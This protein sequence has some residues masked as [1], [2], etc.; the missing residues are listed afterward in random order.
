MPTS[1]SRWASAFVPA[2]GC[3]SAVPWA[4][5]IVAAAYRAGAPYVQVMW[6]D[7][8]VAKSRYLLAPDGSFGEVPYGQ[9]EAMEGMAERGD[10]VVSISASDPE[11]FAAGS[12]RS[13]E[14]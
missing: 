10:A 8:E 4:R 7:E 5:R 9:A 14:H 6:S 2:S 13:E 12:D 3:C 1:P 11:A